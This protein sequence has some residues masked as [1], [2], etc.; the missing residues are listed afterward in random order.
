MEN[1]K[2]DIK[3]EDG[4]MVMKTD[5][6]QDGVPSSVLNLHMSEAIQELIAKGVKKEDVKVVDFELSPLGLK[7]VLDTDRDGEALMDYSISFG[8]GFD[9]ALGKFKK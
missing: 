9:E 8:E 5:M 3:V 6:D 7:L 1:K 2:L 4:K